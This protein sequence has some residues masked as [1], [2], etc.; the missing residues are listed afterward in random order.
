MKKVIIIL[1]FAAFAITAK[2]QEPI[3]EEP[4]IE[5]PEIDVSK[6]DSAMVAYLM[7]AADTIVDLRTMR[8]RPLIVA[9]TLLNYYS[10]YFNYGL[11]V[12][13]IMMLFWTESGERVRVWFEKGKQPNVIIQGEPQHNLMPVFIKEE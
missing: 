5:E 4:I 11:G 2:A 9:D 8:I 13:R 1:I 12:E 3:I 7:Q 10:T 6:P